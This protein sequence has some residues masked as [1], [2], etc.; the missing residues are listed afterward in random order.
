MKLYELSTIKPLLERHGFHFSKSLGQNFLI[1]EWV[2]QRI[3]QV[4]NVDDGCG[5]LEIGPGI[6]VLTQELCGAAKKVVSVELDTALLPVLD[7]TLAEFDNVKIINQDV[8]KLDIGSLLDAEFAGLRPMACAN[9]PYNITTPV[10]KALLELDRFEQI[11][12]MIQKE[13]AQRICAKPGTAEYGAFSLFVR[14]YA[15]PTICFDVPPGCF[16]PQPKVTSSVITL[17]R[18]AP[19][20]GLL[21]KE[22][23]FSLTRAAFAQRRKTLVNGLSPLFA[24][25]LNKAE[26]IQVLAD[27]GFDERVRGET[28]SLAEF[29]RLS[30]RFSQI[31]NP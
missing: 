26:I 29:T 15:K 16:H 12:V 24:G 17:E 30:N 5:V 27:C 13:V 20:E 10:L 11:T 8:L 4:S 31:L 22:M 14:Y 21:D 1:Q 25:K 19:P 7:E 3:L 18:I 9:L 6:G 28:L 2:P 23:L